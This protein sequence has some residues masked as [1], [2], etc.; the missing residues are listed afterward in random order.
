MP[1]QPISFPMLSFEQ[2]NPSLVGAKYGQEMAQSG[3]KF[4]LE[5][6]ARK[7]AN[8]I[9]AVNAQYAEPLKMEELEKAQL[10]NQYYGP[11][12]QSQIGLRGAQAGLAGAQAGLA[13]TE[14]EKLRFLM[15]NP[16][17]MNPE[18]ALLQ[19]ALQNTQQGGQQP[20]AMGGGAPSA[21]GMPAAPQMAGMPAGGQTANAQQYSLSPN[22]PPLQNLPQTGNPIVDAILAKKFMTPQQEAELGIWKENQRENVV[23]YNKGLE[24]SSKATDNAIT[25]N[26]YIDKFK[27]S[28]EESK[29][30]GTGVLGGQVPSY[31]AAASLAPWHDFSPEQQAD[32]ASQ[33]LQAALIPLL[34][35]GNLSNNELSFLGGL[36]LNRGMTQKSVEHVS[37]YLKAANNRTIEYQSFL[38]AAKS[39]GVDK[40]TADNIWNLYKEQRPIIDTNSGEINHDFTKTWSDYLTPAAVK[41]VQTGTKWE[42]PITDADIKHTARLNKMS[43]AE[44]R[45]MLKAEGRL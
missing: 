4:P 13:G 40:W 8:A 33:N 35:T 41:S 38:N 34:K 19:Y 2:A 30:K 29:F 11:D 26:Q 20:S 44:V 3:L 24:E 15:K 45:K 42:P 36:K 39:K 37:E 25:M 23:N 17:Y 27:K 21:L 9:A 5:Q 7:L 14:A 1:I 16:I 28:Y 10:Y 6:E 22:A 12:I 18:A 32:Q 31:G 43:E